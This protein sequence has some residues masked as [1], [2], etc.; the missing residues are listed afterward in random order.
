ML[1]PGQTLG[2]YRIVRLLREG[3][4]AE[5][6]LALDDDRQVLLKLFRAGVIEAAALPDLQAF[7]QILRAASCSHLVPLSEVAFG[8]DL[9]QNRALIVRPWV[10]GK[11]LGEQLARTPVFE[12]GDVNKLARSVLEALDRVHQAGL[13]VQSLRPSNII[14][15]PDGAVRF[16]DAGFWLEDESETAM[17]QYLAPEQQ[18]SG[19]GSVVADLYAVGVVLYRAL[20]GS[21]PFPASAP[22][23]L[24][25]H[26]ISSNMASIPRGGRLIVRLV[27][28]LLAPDPAARPQSAPA[29]LAMLES[30]DANPGSLLPPSSFNTSLPG[31]KRLPSIPP[32]PAMR[33]FPTPAAGVAGI[34]PAA[35]VTGIVPAAAQVIAAA[36]GAGAIVAKAR[37]TGKTAVLESPREATGPAYRPLS[38]LGPSR[39]AHR[40]L[41]VI[42]LFAVAVF[43]FV[44]R[45]RTPPPIELVPPPHSR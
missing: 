44:L 13:A 41:V 9:D 38:S 42:A 18:V 25:Q 2:R 22:E 33:G 4:A 17:F 11:S 45:P 37:I 23:H 26:K 43:A 40:V 15:A 27:T 36:G 39:A 29:T 35:G 10:E 14:T 7:A 30:M 6:Y 12:L 21:L 34:T 19:E 1:A 20:T 5:S 31:I 16:T 28:A 32:R 8:Q 24:L 3:Q